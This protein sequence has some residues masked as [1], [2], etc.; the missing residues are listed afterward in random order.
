[1]EA[2]KSATHRSCNG[3][4][5]A[6]WEEGKGRRKSTEIVRQSNGKLDEVIMAAKDFT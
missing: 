4:G 2:L 5:S 3:S 1:M 6:E